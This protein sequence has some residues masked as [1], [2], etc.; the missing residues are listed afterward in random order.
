MPEAG[1]IVSVAAMMAVGANTE[2]QREVRGL[3]VR[4]SEAV[5][6]RS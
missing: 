3:K 5:E 1:R 6:L 2:G 4:A